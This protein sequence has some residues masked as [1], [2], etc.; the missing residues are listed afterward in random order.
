MG[1]LNK[2]ELIQEYEP[3]VNDFYKLVSPPRLADQHTEQLKEWLNAQLKDQ[4][5]AWVTVCSP[6]Q[7][8]PT[9]SFV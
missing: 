9:L 6:T 7:P 4:K 3:A 5:I 8:S 1:S 2:E